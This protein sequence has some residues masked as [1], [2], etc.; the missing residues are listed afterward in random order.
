VIALSHSEGSGGFEREFLI[1][2]ARR[3]EKAVAQFAAH[4]RT[5]AWIWLKKNHPQRAKMSGEVERLAGLACQAIVQ[6]PE[7]WTE[8]GNLGGLLRRLCVVNVRPERA[9]SGE[10]AIAAPAD[11]SPDWS[12]GGYSDS[13]RRLLDELPAKDRELLIGVFRQEERP[14]PGSSE[15]A[16]LRLLLFRAR[17][18]FRDLLAATTASSIPPV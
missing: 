16:Y 8:P 11:G 14:Q 17:L 2:V 9:G 13:V 12:S 6:S 3:D 4:V 15:G 7:E 18:R 5:V 10:A 1:R